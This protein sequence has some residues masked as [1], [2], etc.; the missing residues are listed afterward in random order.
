MQFDLSRLYESDMVAVHCPDRSTAIAFVRF[1]KDRHPDKYFRG[2]P[3]DSEYWHKHKEETCYRPRLK[4]GPSM[5]YC[6]REFYENGRY[7]IIEVQ[8]LMMPL[9]LELP[10]IHEVDIKSLFGME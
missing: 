4:D 1:I 9:D 5:Q 10:P 6:D 7:E 2:Y 8:E 3:G